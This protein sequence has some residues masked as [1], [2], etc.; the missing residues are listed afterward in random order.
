MENDNR[1]LKFI[2]FHAENI[3]STKMYE[4]ILRKI[5]RHSVVKV[6]RDTP[7]NFFG[8]YLSFIRP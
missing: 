6:V 4:R 2:K 7:T 1:N 5:E 8:Y 3:T